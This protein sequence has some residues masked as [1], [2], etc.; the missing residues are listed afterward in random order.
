[1][2]PPNRIHVIGAR[3]HNLKG[4]DVHIPRGALTVITGLSGS[5]KSSLAFD[6]IYAE[7]QRKYVESLSAYARQFLEQMQKPDVDRIEGLSPTVAIEQR[8]PTVSPRSTVATTTE[9]HD[10]LRVLYA[11]VGEPHCW[12]CGRPIGRQTTTQIVDTVLAGPEGQR[13]LV[14]APLAK[15]QR[16][17]HRALLDQVRKQGFLRARIDGE[18]ALLE[19]HEALNPARRHSIDV[20]VDRLTLKPGLTA[21]LT[22]SIETALRLTA[23]RV[24]LAEV[25]D[26]GE[27]HDRVFSTALACPL[28]PEVRL[29]ELTPQLF[30]FNSPEGAC[31][32]CH[33]LGITMEFD[34]TLIAP[35]R[36]LSLGRGAIAAGQQPGNR[37]RAS[38][39]QMLASFCRD[40]K[41]SAEVPLRKLAPDLLRILMHGTTPADEAAHGAAFEGIIPHLKQR[42]E[43]TESETLKQRLHAFLAET[44]CVAC[45]G[46]RLTPAARA[47]RVAGLGIAEV[48]AMTVTRA[49]VWF[50]ELTFT[51][52]P[53]AVAEP[54]LHGLRHRLKFLCDV[55]V[56]Y[57]TLDRRSATLSGG[58]G[59]RIRLGTQI[60]SGLAGICY[61]LDEPTCG[62]HARDGARLATI[63]RQ[64]TAL[65]NT[66]IVV[67]HD[68][69][70]IA[71][72]DYI[73]DIGPG[74]GANGGHVVCQGSRADL[75]KCS[76]SLTAAYLTGRAEIPVPEQRRPP[77]PRRILELKGAEA[78]NLKKINA[79]FPLGC[80][81][82]VTGVSGSG[83][84]T[85]VTQTLLPVLKRGLY[86]SGP[87][88]GAFQRIVGS[89]K[90][91][92]VV[93]VDQS[94]IGRTP[95][96]TPATYV[97]VFDLVRRLYARTREAKV[98]GYGP[99]R[100]SFNVPGGRC[101]DCQGQGLKRLEMHFLPDMY[102]TCGSCHGT[103]Y[104]RETLEVRYRGKNIADV[105][106][107]R[108]AEAVRFFENFNHIRQ[109]LQTLKD[110][111]LGYLTLGQA[112]NTLSG[113]EAQR[114]KLAAELF[115]TPDAHTVYILDEPTT[116]L[117]PA[118]VQQ[119]LGVLNRLAD[120]GHTIIVIEHNLDV[121]KSADWIIDLGPEGGD[122]GGHIVAE[123]TPE[124]VAEHPTSYTGKYLRAR[125]NA[126]A[127]D[128]KA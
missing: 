32:V 97:G 54:L 51:G 40:F 71:A 121:I 26:T 76:A 111:G 101:E 122:A 80:F 8:A 14:L 49:R 96:S 72:A 9:I 105:L 56:D 109:R 35:D 116:G 126:P 6:T 57:L 92:A 33:G 18:V 16:G 88:P 95:R 42:Y 27:L 23:G 60:G 65:D 102:V 31:P 19:Q 7:G 4:I 38:L 98:R 81:I 70:I 120:R 3:Q 90:V 25:T 128:A 24:V 78:N 117:H 34:E 83:K 84:S 5:G 36:G 20:V 48:T 89:E 43:S 85:L 28:H 11:R 107:L 94:P 50:D 45:R 119:L 66:V 127:P 17:S 22:D 1:M 113:G 104:G 52:E 47:V 55:G 73:V 59:Q 93:E 74:A 87:R 91:E 12:E 21:R 39:A 114:V 125:L 82:C 44:P 46:T 86:R 41:A 68:D 77:D 123:G 67:E 30:S 15:D 112:S 10:Y 37:G 75:L 124:Q 99:P 63:L 115:K 58:E 103:R 118:D 108:V 79:R 2:S 61:V 69:Q 29:D 62:L 53:A 106:D 110:V 13:L 100:F 64:L